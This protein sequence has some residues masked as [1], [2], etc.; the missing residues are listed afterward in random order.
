MTDPVVNRVG[1]LKVVHE[2]I[3]DLYNT[4]RAD[5][6]KVL[7]EGSRIPVRTPEGEKIATV[8]KTDPVRTARINNESAFEAWVRANHPE[9]IKT[10]QVISGTENA[11]IKVLFTHAPHLLRAHTVVDPEL[12]KE[13][14]R[15][16]AKLGTPVGP[17]GETDIEGVVVERPEGTV[18]C[19]PDEDGLA[20]VIQM[21]RSGVLTF[22]GLAQI[23]GPEG[24]A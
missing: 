11:V 5:A 22:E 24:A 9:R 4:A 13:V 8:S 17:E 7:S 16:S 21:F 10:V 20:E 3:T 18:T 2:H 14:K 15:L 1:V 6:S 12:V 23:E 19:R